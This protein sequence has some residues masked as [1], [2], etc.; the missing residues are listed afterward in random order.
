MIK[1]FIP[2]CDRYIHLI[3]SLKITVEEFLE[4]PKSFQFNIVGYKKPNWELN[5]WVFHSLGEDRGPQYFT[6]D[7]ESF[8]SKVEDEIFIYLNDDILLT[9]KLNYDLLIFLIEKI[10][11][12]EKIGRICLTDD[13]TYR[14]TVDTKSIGYDVIETINDTN[15]IEYRQNSDYRI[16]T[17]CSIW[18]KN[19]LL[20]YLDIDY[21][22][23]DFEVL[24][25]QKSI[26]D[27]Y[28]ILASS[29]NFVIPSFSH[30]MVRGNLNSHWYVDI[31]N[32]YRLSDTIIEKIKNKL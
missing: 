13:G 10:K 21:N 19:Y 14:R 32:R 24:Q 2:T 15:I 31:R 26:N 5:D 20:K 17:Q 8:F 25:S 28:R 18:R 1:V 11:S 12:D 7:L 4:N 22:P 6:R 29:N 9:H 23:W 3:E 16:S 27:G 30:L